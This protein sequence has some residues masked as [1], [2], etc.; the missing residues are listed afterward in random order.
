VTSAMLCLPTSCL[1]V[2][3]SDVRA[4][5]RI[6]TRVGEP[7]RSGA[8]PVEQSIAAWRDFVSARTP[9]YGRLQKLLREMPE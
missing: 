5:G 3:D 6:E 4:T 8:C 7:A 2:F 9:S 1:K